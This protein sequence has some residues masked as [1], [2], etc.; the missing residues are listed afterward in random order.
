MTQLKMFRWKGVNRLNQS[1]KGILI[2]ENEQQARQILL[3][4]GWQKLKLQQNW[5]LSTKPT[6]AEICDALLQLAVLLKSA[7]PLKNSLV[8]LLQNC[9]NI[10]LNQWIRILIHE[11]ETGY[12]FSQALA[13]QATQYAFLN[14]QERQLIHVG[15]MT[16]K[17]P[18][19]CAQIAEHK[20]Q[21][22]TLQRKLQKILLYPILV[23]AISIILTAL[24]LIFIVPQFADMYSNNQAQLPFFTQILLSLSNS[25]QDYW[26]LML[27][28]IVAL[29]AVLKHQLKHSL[30]LNQCKNKLSETM[31]ILSNVVHL[32]RLV[33]F[34]R[35]LHLMLLSGVP[36]N[37]ALQSFLPQ[38]K[39]WQQ[40]A[41]VQGDLSLI[42]EVKAMLHWVKQG[43]AFSAA[44]GTG[45]FPMQA[46]QM[47]QVGE[48]SGQLA[49]MLKH[50]ADTY[51]QQLDH[52]IDL[53]SQMLEPLLMVVIGG[54][55][56]LIMLGLYLPIF[57]MGSLIQ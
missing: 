56:G 20:Q 23:L 18:Q 57:N 5:Q 32:S 19:V 2:A 53:L 42:S 44:V 27:C 8:I 48:Q 22:L 45:L 38:Q 10:Q 34:C 15:E 26:A 14:L 36:L 9:T 39:S 35:S 6:Q 3:Q 37:Q 16:G 49:Q 30:R 40:K 50:I 25:L 29:I 52:K 12:S 13:K 28:L 4:R 43:Y 51:Q 41:D 24:L 55:I 21:A 31:P 54:L 47:L 7:V 46:Q 1:Q 33:S 17:L 11:I